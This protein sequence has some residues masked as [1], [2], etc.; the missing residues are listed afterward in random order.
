MKTIYVVYETDNHQSLDSVCIKVLTTSKKEAKKFYNTN[1]KDY[2]NDWYLILSKLEST[3][4][5]SIDNNL[6]RDLD[7]IKQSKN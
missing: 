7:I 4:D 6:I 5:F 2:E 3:T 1:K